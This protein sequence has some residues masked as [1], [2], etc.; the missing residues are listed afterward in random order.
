MAQS[1]PGLWSIVKAFPFSQVLS[2]FISRIK[3]PFASRVVPDSLVIVPVGPSD[4]N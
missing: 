2:I 4:K 3:A 1:A